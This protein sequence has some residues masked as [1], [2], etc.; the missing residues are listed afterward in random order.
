MLLGKQ[1][2]LGS[3]VWTSNDNSQLLWA[4]NRNV[5]LFSIVVWESS[6]NR[7]LLFERAMEYIIIIGQTMK[8]YNCRLDRQ[9]KFNNSF[10]IHLIIT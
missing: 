5:V 4:S 8:T 1:W 9:W 7:E 10:R 3:I 6:G 2:K